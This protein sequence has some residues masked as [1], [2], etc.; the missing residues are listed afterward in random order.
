MSDLTEFLLARIAE[1][2]ANAK[3]DIEH[4]ESNAPFDRWLVDTY[5]KPKVSE[6]VTKRRIIE[7]AYLTTADQCHTDLLTALALSYAGHPDYRDEWR[8]E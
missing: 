7:V 2:E 6:C 1:D 8:I 3:S 4:F 5:L